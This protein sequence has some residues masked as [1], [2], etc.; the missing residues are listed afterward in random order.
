MRQPLQLRLRPPGLGVV[1]G[2]VRGGGGGRLPESLALR[3]SPP[4]GEQ[5]NRPRRRVAAGRG[6]CGPAPPSPSLSPFSQCWVPAPIHPPPGT[7]SYPLQVPS[8]SAPPL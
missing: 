8:A 3:G 6:L 2:L 7:T 4:S 5:N 1:L